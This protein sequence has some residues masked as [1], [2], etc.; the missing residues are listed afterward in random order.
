MIKP[1]FGITGM[2]CA[3]LCRFFTIILLPVLVMTASAAERSV[4][5]TESA[6]Y[7]IVSDKGEDPGIAESFDR[8]FTSQADEVY[9]KIGVKCPE[10]FRV[11]LCIGAWIFKKEA[12]LDAHTSAVYLPSRKTFVFQNPK[13]LERRG[14]LIKTARHELCHAAIDEW[15]SRAGIE[16]N[17]EKRWLEESLCTALYPADDYSPG[18][19]EKILSSMNGSERKIS[20]Y[21][22]KNLYSPDY[23]ER[24]KAY[25]LAYAYGSSVLKNKKIGDA[26][27]GLK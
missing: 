6:L 21:L 17:P 24:R 2:S 16:F 22:R 13:S 10:Q 7:T 4:V 26:L 15:R 5:R 3:K 9:A 8:V 27:G 12:G 1:I 25:S 23:A 14:I 20:A 11:T 19:G 18:E